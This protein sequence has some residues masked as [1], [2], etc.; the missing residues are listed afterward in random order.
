MILAA[1][2]VVAVAAYAVGWHYV[3]GEIATRTG[4]A[5]AAVNRDGRRAACEDLDVRGFPFRIGIFCRGV[6]YIDQR[7]ATSIRAGAFR[8]AA[9]VYN[10]F[11]AV[12]EL[13]GPATIEVPGLMA[14]DF[15]WQSLRA[16]ARLALPLP[17]R[18]SL[19]ARGLT[20]DPDFGP[21]QAPPLL[22]MEAGEAHMRPVGA[23]VDV[24]LRFEGLGIGEELAGA[25]EVPPLG[26]FVD[27]VLLGALSPQAEL[28]SLRGRSAELRRVTVTTGAGA[29]ITVSGPVSVAADGLVDAD[30]SLTL[31]SPS[32]LAAILGTVFPEARSDIEM[33]AG[34]I[35][36]AGEDAVLPLRIVRGEMRLG[37]ISLG[38]IPPI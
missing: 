25:A 16:S 23:D 38:S 19:E 36:A 20:V 26:G 34:V 7:E 5:I 18:L 32:E 21:G 29:G 3:A 33:A 22:T 35:A 14:L 13:D 15:N 17:E 10:P 12:G 30:L 9:Q 6:M 1:V 31:H 4:Q 27:A 2:I 28:A 37:F 8:S 11:R 24:A